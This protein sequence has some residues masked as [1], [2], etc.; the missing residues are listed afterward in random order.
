MLLFKVAQ[1]HV[2]FTS[3][4]FSLV[5]RDRPDGYKICRNKKNLPY[6]FVF[7]EPFRINSSSK[8]WNIS[9]SGRPCLGIF[10]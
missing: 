1:S 10:I 8:I 3:L 4:F 6:E 7:L 2:N 5:K 9:W